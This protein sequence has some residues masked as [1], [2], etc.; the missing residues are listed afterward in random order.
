M[1]KRFWLGMMA[2]LILGGLLSYSASAAGTGTLSVFADD[3]NTD[4]F[5]N[6]EFLGKGNIKK[7]INPGTYFLSGKLNGKTIYNESV[8]IKA[9][10]INSI[11]VVRVL[12]RK[13]LDVRHL[14]V[15]LTA[16]GISTSG[17]HI[18]WY[19]GDLGFETIVG[20]GG[21][22]KSQTWN[23]SSYTTYETPSVTTYEARLGMKVKDALGGMASVVLGVGKNYVMEDRPFLSFS[24]PTFETINYV[25]AL[26][27]L[28][29]S[30]LWGME[31]LGWSVEFGY[32]AA[33]T[34]EKDS[35]GLQKDRSGIAVGFGLTYWLN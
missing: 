34:E 7:E 13:T 35:T 32:R 19:P 14:G 15:G 33:K 30:D 10:E 8:T 29:G 17:F 24:D 31:D 3:N 11:R 18:K 20:T 4:L 21:G 2:F 5:L 25:Q 23:G 1:K 26:V 27:V 28:N 9:S 22:Y 16:N 12:E 6:N